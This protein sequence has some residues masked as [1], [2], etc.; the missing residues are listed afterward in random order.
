MPPLRYADAPAA[1]DEPVQLLLPAVSAAAARRAVRVVTLARGQ[2]V[3]H[4]PLQEVD[5][6]QQPLGDLAPSGVSS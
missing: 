3:V 6:G 1:V 4:R 5:E 2:H